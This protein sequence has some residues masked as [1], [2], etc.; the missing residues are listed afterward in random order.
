[1]ELTSKNHIQVLGDWVLIKHPDVVVDVAQIA[2][3][4]SEEAQNIP[5]NSII[6][7]VYFSPDQRIYFAGGDYLPF[8][9]LPMP[10]NSGQL[11]IGQLPRIKEVAF[12]PLWCA[13]IPKEIYKKY[14]F[15]DVFGDDV[16]DHADVEMQMRR[17]GVKFYI[18]G[19][20]H[21]VYPH[22]YEPI[23]GKEKF[24]KMIETH[25]RDFN[26]KWARYIDAQ[27]RLPV[28]FHSVMAFSGG[29]NYHAFNVAY[30]LFKKRIRTFY[31]FIGGTNEDEAESGMHFIDDYKVRYGSMRFPQ[32]TL[33]HGTNNFKNS[34]DYK[35]AFST[36]EVSGIPQ[37]WVKCFNEM[38]E[39]WATSE[40]ARQ[41]F[42]KSGVVVPVFNIGEGV[43]SETFNPDIAPFSN[44]PKETFRFFSNF[45][46]GKRKGVDLLFEAFR[47][48]FS[49][50]EDVCLMLKCLKSYQGHNIKDEMAKLFDR[51]GAAPIYMYEVELEKYELGRMYNMAQVFVWPSRGEGFGLP[52]IEAAA[53]GMPIIA[54]NHSAHLEFLLKDGK[55]LPGVLLL[56]GKIVDYDGGDSMYY[57][58]FKWF[59]PDIND[60]RKKMRYAFEHYKELKEKA[61]ET[62]EYIRKEFDW[63][64]S[65]DRIIA[66]LE[67]IY[68][69]K[70][71]SAKKPYSYN[72]A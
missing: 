8:T 63:G 70:W 14:K 13:L 71:I 55:P 68:S 21:T 66:R 52:A 10:W 5:P 39:V 48:E 17:D 16:L 12:T 41:A 47:R 27:Y 58:G 64:I 69:K 7:P 46:W 37:D 19:R 42:I 35:I 43:D 31:Q 4:L 49:K 1:M 34:G 2:Q 65:T 54:S 24:T 33:C 67:E 44:P 62:S 23:I 53:C 59:E 32:I 3:S 18:A 38:D 29:Y 15:M 25:H 45:A 28:V 22:A 20:I 26:Q 60:L 6:T 56:D 72:D 30:N 11:W 57:P 61:L 50:D 9:H 51:K 36:T 40:F